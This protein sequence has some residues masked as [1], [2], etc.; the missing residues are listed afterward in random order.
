[1]ALLSI[2]VGGQHIYIDLLELPFPI[3][4]RSRNPSLEFFTLGTVNKTK[5]LQ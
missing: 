2:A 1:M 3:S 5:E 4:V